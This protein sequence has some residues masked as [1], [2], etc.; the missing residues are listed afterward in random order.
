MV[1][2]ADITAK[3]GVS[4]EE[5]FRSGGSARGISDAVYEFATIANDHMMTARDMATE[6][7]SQAMPVMM[8]GVNTLILELTC[9]R[10]L[11]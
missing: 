4:Q 5:V 1:I 8:C 9:T 11:T 3:H 10:K 7:P 2:P 6:V